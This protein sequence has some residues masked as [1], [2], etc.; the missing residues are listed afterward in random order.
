MQRDKKHLLVV[1][2]QPLDRKRYNNDFCGSIWKTCTLR[3]WLNSKFYKQAFNEQER[4]C[5]AKTSIENNVGPKTKDS[6]FLLSIDEV[7]S[8]FADNRLRYAK[9]TD[10]AVKN[11]ARL[12]HSCCK[13]WLRS[14]GINSLNAGYV[15]N[16]GIVQEVGGFTLLDIVAVRPALKL[17]L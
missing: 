1:A 8:L 7:Q 4:E 6:V 12:R 9:P 14:S 13:W 16:E 5:I 10:Y 3:R 17:N 15:D 2:K 11:G